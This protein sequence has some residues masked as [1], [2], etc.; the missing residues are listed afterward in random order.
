MIVPLGAVYQSS[1]GP[2]SSLWD[3]ITH[4]IDALSYTGEAIS[5]TASG[6]MAPDMSNLP[7]PI[8][9]SQGAPTNYSQLSVTGAWTPLDAA[10]TGLANEQLANSNMLIDY[11]NSLTS[12]GV[13]W[14]TVA[15]ILGV[16]ALALWGLKK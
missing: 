15:I 11:T 5:S 2:N 10:T 14:C 12:N 6:I 3:I 1:I 4:P 16:G 7:N 9:P 8:V 13:P